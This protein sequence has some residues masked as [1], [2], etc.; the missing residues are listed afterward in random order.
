MQYRKTLQIQLAIIAAAVFFLASCEE[1]PPHIDFTPESTDTTLLDTTY[2]SSTPI[3]EQAKVVLLEDFTGVRC[4][5][6]PDAQQ[7]AKE[8][9]NAN[10]P[11]VVVMALH[12]TSF[13]EP[14]P[15]SRYNFRLQSADNV[16]NMLG[17]APG[18]PM[19]AIDRT[20]FSGE[21]DVLVAFQKWDSYV[22]NRL[23]QTTPVKIDLESEYN[24][25]SN[26]AKIR[27]TVEYANAAGENHY[28]SLAILESKMTD[29]QLATTGKISNYEH[30]H[31]LRRFVTP[32]DG[33]R[34]NANLERGRVFIKEY[35]VKLDEDW[36]PEN[37]SVMAF[38]H[39][40]I[41]SHQVHQANEIDLIP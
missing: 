38:V 20:I 31:T 19:G 24:A 11:G 23:A 37:C 3:S 14:Y 34:L 4:V 35:R 16:F 32:F 25:D 26:E 28:L 30:N 18:L 17:G 10:R 27:I 6:C 13:A 1:V 29:V 15:E 21:Q 8:I 36:E 7:R 39:E 9:Q 12:A 5:N 40:K 2:V 41:N 22:Q 33:Q